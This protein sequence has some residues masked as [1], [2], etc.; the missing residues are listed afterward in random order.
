MAR[1]IIKL[2]KISFTLGTL[3]HFRHFTGDSVKKP[4]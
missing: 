3:G 1:S 2:T 4:L